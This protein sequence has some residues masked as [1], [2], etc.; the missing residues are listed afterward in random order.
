MRKFGVLNYLEGI[1]DKALKDYTKWILFSAENVED[2]AFNFTSH[3]ASEMDRH[4]PPSIKPHVYK[5]KEIFLPFVD[6]YNEL[7]KAVLKELDLTVRERSLMFCIMEY[8]EMDDE[9]TWDEYRQEFGEFHSA[10]TKITPED[11][12]FIDFWIKKDG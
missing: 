6:A 3:D 2:L 8:K 4:L 1:K 5:V 7:V 11:Q 10:L 12:E 9:L